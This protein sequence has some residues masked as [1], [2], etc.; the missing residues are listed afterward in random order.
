MDC[1]FVYPGPEYSVNSIMLFENHTW[2]DSI[3]HFYPQVDK[4]KFTLLP[5]YDKKGYLRDMCTDMLQKLC[6][7]GEVEREIFDK[8][9]KY[10]EHWQLHKNQIED[11]FSE[12]FQLNTTKILSNMVGNVTFNPIC[13]RFLSTNS[14]DVFYLNSERGA[15]GIA[16]HEII[17]FLWFYVWKK[18]FNDSEEEYETPH[19]KWLFSEMVVDPIMRKDPRLSSINPYFED[20]CAYDYFYTMKVD[21]KPMLET[22]YQMYTSLDILEFMEQGFAYCQRHEGEIKAQIP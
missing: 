20:R 6:R 7:E 13:P 1:K 17:H 15:L 9:I 18:H 2:M 8:L 14:F 22:L 3:F 4:A 21:E 16:L 19:L 12:A 5:T 10:N 11:A